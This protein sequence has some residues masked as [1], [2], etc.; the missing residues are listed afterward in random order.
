VIAELAAHDP[1]FF[2]TPFSPQF[3][4]V[5]LDVSVPHALPLHLERAQAAS[6][7][8]ISGVTG[9]SPADFERLQEASSRIPI[10]YSP[11]F[12]LGVALFRQLARQAAL[13]FPEA[14]YALIDTHHAAKKDAPSGTA[15]LIAQEIA[16]PIAIHSIRA[17]THPG[18]HELRLS[19]AD[20]TIELS[21]RLL[22]RKPLAL[23][24][25][26]AVRFLYEKPAGLY[27]IDELLP[28]N[29]LHVP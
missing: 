11:N 9:Y 25:L 28:Q 14:H 20:E 17:G 19:L 7:P 10:L 18:S 15:R 1:A 22:S 24:A 4:G 2:L 16:H 13:A 8:Y 29:P 21:H 5:F 6:S 26:A 3:K 27:S 12:S 23:G